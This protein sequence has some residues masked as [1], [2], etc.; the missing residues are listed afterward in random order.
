MKDARELCHQIQNTCPNST[1]TISSIITRND[2]E[3]GFKVF[4][5]NNL[6]RQLCEKNSYRFLT[7]DNIDKRCLNRSGLHL[8]K[9]GDS[10]LAKNIIELI[11]GFECRPDL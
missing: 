4:E 11:K 3:N 8:N 6:L 2:D 10:K 7:H 5:V 1:I 9:Y